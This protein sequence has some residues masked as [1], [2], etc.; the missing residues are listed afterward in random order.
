MPPR[1]QNPDMAQAA[2]AD[3]LAHQLGKGKPAAPVFALTPA[4]IGNGNKFLD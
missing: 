1:P 2:N 4:L 3:A